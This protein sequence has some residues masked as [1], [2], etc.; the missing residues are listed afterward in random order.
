[1]TYKLISVVGDGVTQEWTLDNELFDGFSVLVDGAVVV[2]TQP[3]WNRVKLS[4]APAAGS[5]V[6]FKVKELASTDASGSTGG[7]GSADASAIASAVAAAVQVPSAAAIATAVAAAVPAAPSAS[8]V[9][10]AVS[11]SLSGVGFVKGE[12]RLIGLEAGQSIPDGWTVD[13]QKTVKPSDFTNSVVVVPQWTTAAASTMCSTQIGTQHVVLNPN[14]GIVTKAGLFSDAATT[15]ATTSGTSSST[16]VPGV[17]G[18]L[19]KFF[20]C[21]GSTGVSSAQLGT[22]EVDLNSGVITQ[23][24]NIPYTCTRM[25]VAEIYGGAV[26]VAGGTAVLSSAVS[27]TLNSI[28]R[29]TR[30]TNTWVVSAAVL[31]VGVVLP[32]MGVLPSGKVFI[33]GGVKTDGT[34][35]NGYVIYDPATDTVSAEASLPFTSLSYVNHTLRTA[36]GVALR[37]AAAGTCFMEYDEALGTW[38]PFAYSVPSNR[39]GTLSS[40]TFVSQCD[41]KAATGGYVLI[42][43]GLFNPCVLLNAELT[44]SYRFIRKL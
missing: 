9:A 20:R 16:G 26:L 6:T 19:G 24:A 43:T 41:L 33:G 13:N 5:N 22:F 18:L 31:P 28:S 10:T 37:I 27:S 34:V 30:S 12:T 21:G 17:C 42:G 11:A 7:A 44:P 36:R 3:A 14:T 1:M 2:Y 40:T 15:V 23:L 29:Y 25:S 32:Y 38:S 35:W 8:Q 4:N 39:F